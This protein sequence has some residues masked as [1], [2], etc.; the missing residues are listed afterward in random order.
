M[1]KSG[2]NKDWYFHYIL[3]TY[4]SSITNTNSIFEDKHGFSKTSDL[5]FYW[6][7]KALK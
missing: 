1:P 3:K 7:D 6:F 2:N 4:Y 5:R